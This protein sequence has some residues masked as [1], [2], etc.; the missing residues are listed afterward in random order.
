[1]TTVN[2]QRRNLMSGAAAFTAM[3]AAGV[4]LG[5]L[6]AEYKSQYRLAAVLPKPYPWGMGAER[7]AE[8]ITEATDGRI[9]SKVY[10]NASLT[11][12]D[13]AKEFAALR[14]GTIDLAICASQNWAGQINELN[15]FSMPFLLPNYAAADAVL[16]SKAAAELFARIEKAGVI[17][18]AWGENGFRELT[19]SKHAV[20]TPADL[21]GLKIRISASAIMIDTFKALGANPTRMSWPDLQPALASRAVDGQENPLHNVLHAKMAALGQKHLSIWNHVYDPLI[22]AASA[23]TW[24][25]WTPK[26]R[27]I[28]RETAPPRIEWWLMIAIMAV[29]AGLT[30]LNVTVRYLTNA[31]FAYTEELSVALMVALAMIGTACA[32]RR[33]HHIRVTFLVDK[34]PA[35][36]KASDVATQLV[37][38]ATFAVLGYY[39]VRQTMDDIEFGVVSAGLG[40]PEWWF[41]SVLPLGCALVCWRAAESLVRLLFA[42]KE[43]TQ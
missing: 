39:G 9:K 20:R 35:A 30:F 2:K 28:V 1:M 4:P 7:W 43:V 41:S 31:S 25:S 12:G 22:F 14:Q 26:D 6:A 40:I 18:L 37:T 19:N 11:G 16:K 8:L 34:R 38:L 5:A 33:D 24:Q 3:A 10:A 21:E 23:R 13:G 15:M 27:E 36:R 29:L 42:R 17:P 32:V